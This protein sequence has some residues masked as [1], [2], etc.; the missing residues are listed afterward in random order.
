[1]AQQRSGGAFMSGSGETQLEIERRTLADLVYL[2]FLLALVLKRAN[3]DDLH[4]ETKIKRE[5]DIIAKT[6]AMHLSARKSSGKPTFAIV[7]YTNAGI[8][9][10]P[11]TLRYGTL[12]FVIIGKSAL[13]N[14]LSG[15]SLVSHDMLFAS[16]H[17]HVRKYGPFFTFKFH[18]L[19]IISF[20]L[21]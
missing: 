13:L 4:Q 21:F 7:G 15:S 19:L 8:T 6:R 3:H 1:M 11:P 10:F 20:S 18:W 14:S 17:T 9:P 2:W 16:L 5:L 12:T